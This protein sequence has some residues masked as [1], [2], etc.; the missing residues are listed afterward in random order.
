MSIFDL[1]SELLRAITSHLDIPSATSLSAASGYF[2]QAADSRL[3]R[4]III[5]HSDQFAPLHNLVPTPPGSP[6]SPVS[7]SF[8]NR[9]IHPNDPSTHRGILRSRGSRSV[10]Q[11]HLDALGLKPW[12]A[13]CVREV[14]IQLGQSIPTELD[15]LLSLVGGGIVDLKL[16]H[17]GHVLLSTQSGSGRSRARSLIDVLGKGREFPRLMKADLEVGI[18]WERSIALILQSAPRLKYL[19]L[20]GDILPDPS[21]ELGDTTT[22]ILE[23]TVLG[24]YTP[25]DD[26]V[27]SSLSLE[28]LD[29]TPLSLPLIPLLATV[30]ANSP[31]LQSFTLTDPSTQWIPT[32]DDPL[33]LALT[34]SREILH[35]AIPSSA[36]PALAL[37]QPQPQLY[38]TPSAL[39]TVENLDVAWTLHDL[40]DAQQSPDYHSPPSRFFTLFPNLPNLRKCT[41]KLRLLDLESTYEVFRGRMFDLSISAIRQHALRTSFTSTPLLECID[42][43]EMY[44]MSNVGPVIPDYGLQAQSGSGRRWDNFDGVLITHF[45]ADDGN[46]HFCHVRHRSAFSCG[47]EHYGILNGAEIKPAAYAALTDLEGVRLSKVE[48][49]IR[50]LSEESWEVL[51]HWTAQL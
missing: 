12:R 43:A 14:D 15:Q 17:P 3:Y 28:V 22:K 30:V 33:I 19:R 31:H 39:K 51:R 47:W 40:N 24:Q 25:M 46:D 36:L 42:M 41:F 35:L 2:E 26:L 5:T 4:F 32:P 38:H 29:I 21:S 27:P 16:T 50:R 45:H 20:R 8:Q 18:S 7:P 9:P 48:P 23:S 10:L 49:G 37:A 6:G 34:R 13:K 11:T 1:P 44:G